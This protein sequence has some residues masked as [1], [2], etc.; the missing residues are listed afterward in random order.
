[1]DREKWAHSFGIGLTGGIATGKST[2]ASIL[3]TMGVLVWDADALAREVVAPGREALSAIVCAFGAE[4]LL[5]SGELDRPKVRKNILLDAAKRKKLESILHPAIHKQLWL[6]LEQA[7]I[8]GTATFW[9]YEAALLFESKT[10]DRF[11][12]IWVTNCSRETQL[13]R[14][15]QRDRLSTEQALQLLQTQGSA[16]EKCRRATRII[17]T[18]GPFPSVQAQVFLFWTQVNTNNGLK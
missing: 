14:L 4:Y 11:L 2:V 6:E 1:M 12:E 7:G 15:C 18:E 10:Q 8:V 3:R 13:S 16:E 5:P 17:D 9:V